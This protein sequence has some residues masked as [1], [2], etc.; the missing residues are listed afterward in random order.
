MQIVQSL[1][2]DYDPVWGSMI[3][4]T[5]RRVFPGFNEE[6]YGYR[7]FAALLEDMGKQKLVELEFDEGRGNYQVRTAS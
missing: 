1:E 5:I 2:R 3:K 4:Q 7:S 6:Y